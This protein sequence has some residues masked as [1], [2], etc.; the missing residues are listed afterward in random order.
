MATLEQAIALAVQA[1]TGQQDKAG[2][3]YILHPLRVM[4][5]Q[6]TDAEMI[7]AVLHDVVEDTPVTLEDLQA[8]GFSAEVL[9]AVESVTH[10]EDE[11]YEAYLERCRANPIGLRVK[12]ADLHDNMDIRRIQTLSQR[13]MARLE[14]YLQAWHFLTRP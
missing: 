6:T 3:P 2:R 10:R 9:A 13:D 7:A 8:A 14:R 12:L 4:L 1:H 11:T 5:A